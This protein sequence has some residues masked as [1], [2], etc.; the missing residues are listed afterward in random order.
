MYYDAHCQH[1]AFSLL[2]S[3]F[4]L[5]LSNQYP[6]KVIIK[7][8]T[9]SSEAS[10]VAVQALQFAVDEINAGGEA[11]FRSCATCVLLTLSYD[12]YYVEAGSSEGWSMVN[13]G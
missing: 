4:S 2:L 13:K 10:N 3:A 1:I 7:S 12:H 9:T 11:P 6:S 5:Q 8:F